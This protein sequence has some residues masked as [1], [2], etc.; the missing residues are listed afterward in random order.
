MWSINFVKTSMHCQEV[1]D[2]LSEATFTW[3]DSMVVLGWI[4]GNHN[5]FK[6]FVRNQIAKIT[7][8][9][10]CDHWHY[11]KGI[12][13]LADST[14]RGLFS[15]ELVAH[16]LWWNGPECLQS[17]L[18]SLAINPRTFC[19]GGKGET[20]IYAFLSLSISTL[21]KCSGVDGQ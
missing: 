15:S 11:V 10:P 18:K 20:S 9:I 17:P 1:F 19:K 16:D 8:V 2:V 4:H 7:S 21:S 12:S 14:F 5:H 13:N 6:P 3:T